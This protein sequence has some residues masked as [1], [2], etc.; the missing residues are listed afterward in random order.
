MVVEAP[1]KQE[2]IL[3]GRITLDMRGQLAGPQLIAILAQA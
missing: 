3:G 2:V 1:L